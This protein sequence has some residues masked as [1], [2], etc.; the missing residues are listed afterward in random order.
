MYMYPLL[1]DGSA[2]PCTQ[3]L[4]HASFAD[5]VNQ[6]DIFLL[7]DMPGFEQLI[8]QPLSFWSGKIKK[9]LQ[10]AEGIFSMVYKG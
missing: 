8:F 3:G 2:A 5:V 4:L 9:S 10:V 1:E 6:Q 7:V